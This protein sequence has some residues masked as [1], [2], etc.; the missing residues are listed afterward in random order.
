MS[1]FV[2]NLLKKE[3]NHFPNNRKY[4]LDFISSLLDK[5]TN[6]MMVSIPSTDEIN[7]DMFS[8]EGEKSL[9]PDCFQCSFFN[10][11]GKQ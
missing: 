6:R 1:E 2:T 9:G 5:D 3:V 11:I 7:K 4:P 8:F 10:I